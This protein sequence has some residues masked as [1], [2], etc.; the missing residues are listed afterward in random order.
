MGFLLEPHIRNPRFL[1]SFFRYTLSTIA[2]LMYG[3]TFVA[4]FLL[5]PHYRHQITAALIFS[6][7]GT[8]TRYLLSIFLNKRLKALPLG[9]LSANIVGTALVASFHVLQTTPSP[10][11][12]TACSILQGLVDGYC[13]CLTTVSTFVAELQDL[14]FWKACRYAILSWTLGQIVMVLILGSSLWTGT[15]RKEVTCIFP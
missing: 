3:A 1:P 6:F 4:Y 15:V 9:T 8:L 11:S 14:R 7:P 5:P 10:P 13:G 12:R 2:I